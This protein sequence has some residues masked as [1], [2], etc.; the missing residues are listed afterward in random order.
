MKHGLLLGALAIMT[1][2]L[3]SVA[4]AQ[5]PP[6]VPSKHTE[7]SSSQDNVEDASAEKPLSLEGWYG[8]QILIGDAAAIGMLAVA[9]EMEKPAWLYGATGAYFLPP[10]IVHAAHRNGGRAAG[11]FALRLAAS[12]VGIKLMYS[13]SSGCGKDPTEYHGPPCSGAPLFVTTIMAGLLDAG[14]LAWDAPPRPSILQPP[15]T[16]SKEAIAVDL[17]PTVATLPGGAYLGLLGSF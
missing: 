17:G 1:A 2:F 11:S 13:D 15:K 9:S 12:V 16:S 14:I 3:P 8:Y 6:T 5:P 10:M 7:E 4:G